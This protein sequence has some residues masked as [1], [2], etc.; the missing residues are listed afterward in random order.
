MKD[1][2]KE[3][4]KKIEKEN[5]KP[6]PKW[7]FKAKE[8]LTMLFFC[9]NIVVGALGTSIIIFLIKNNEV[10][11]DGSYVKNF[12]EWIILSIPFV[13]FLLTVLG[14]VLAFLFLKK[15]KDGYRYDF[16]V[17]VVVNL[18]LS[19]SIGSVIYSLGYTEKLNNYFNTNIPSYSRYFDPRV[20]VWSRPASGYLAGTIV[21]V[22][23]DVIIVDFN[24]KRWNIDIKDLNIII[25]GRVSLVIGEKIKVIGKQTGDNTF[26]A[27]E[28]RPWMGG[29]MRRGNMMQ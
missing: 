25:A 23:E 21:E 28:I 6:I 3:V 26:K 4:I 8:L 29:A 15:T 10:V 22:K 17:L 2:T 11:F 7:E 19:I 16:W 20:N 5:V 18:I 13:W 27:L 12:G 24:L 1:V 14:L 9:L